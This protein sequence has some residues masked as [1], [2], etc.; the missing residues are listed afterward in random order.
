MTPALVCA[1]VAVASATDAG[2]GPAPEA[3]VTLSTLD[4]PT[5]LDGPHWACADV[6]DD[7]ARATGPRLPADFKPVDF[8]PVGLPQDKDAPV[9]TGAHVVFRTTLVVPEAMR[10]TP[11]GISPGEVRGAYRV[12]ADGVVVGERGSFAPLDDAVRAGAGFALPARTVADGEVDLEIEVVRDAAALATT[13]DRRAV[14]GGPVSAGQMPGVADRAVAE[15][16][17]RVFSQTAATIAL[18]ALFFF[19]GFYHVLIWWL[20]RDLRGYLWFGVFALTAVAWNSI[21]VLAGT[22]T[23]PWT[24]RTAA[25]VGNFVGSLAN[26]TFIEFFWWFLTKHAPPRRWR[27]AEALLFACACVGFIPAVGVGWTVS[28]PVVILKIAILPWAVFE[29]VRMA[30]TNRDARVLIVG[31]ALG[32]AGAPLQWFVQTRAIQMPIGPGQAALAI[33]FVTMAVALAVQFGRTLDAVDARAKELAETNASIQRFVP[34]AFL[35]A[36]SRESVREVKRGDAAATQMSVMF[37]DLRGFTTL[38]EKMGPGDTFRFINRYLEKMEPRIHAAGGFINQYLGDG[39]MALFPDGADAA[40]DA[41]VGMARALEGLNQERASDGAPALRI[42]IGIHTGPL[43]IGTIGGGDQLDS[44]VVGDVVNT[45]ARLEGITKMYGAVAL[46]SGATMAGLKDPAA[47]GLRPLDAVRAKGKSE[48][49]AL[50]ELVDADDK[51][52]RAAKLAARGDLEAALALYRKGSFDEAAER[53][54]AL[55]AAIPEDGAARAFAARCRSLAKD[56]AADVGR[57]PRAHDKV[58]PAGLICRRRYRSR[59]RCR[60]SSRSCTRTRC[61]NCRRRP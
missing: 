28:A 54:D 16:H 38:A 60:C 7:G 20:R 46:I 57:R 37:C 30:R 41:A 23:L 8:K 17:A 33:F 56:S 32:V 18:A 45:A 44:G 51:S 61:R 36:L 48:P 5:P 58:T 10:A 34:F 26:L 47:H 24:A 1:L 14:V 53:F 27:I 11:L 22:P 4:P 55:A 12:T 13:Q 3:R 9:C 19:I 49:L 50:V 59:T 39:I 42:G 35:R 15:V 40:V 25:I 6:P 31:L 21:V 2:G 43:M 29:I 52:L